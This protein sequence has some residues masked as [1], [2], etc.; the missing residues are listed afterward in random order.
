VRVLGND[1]VSRV[2]HVLRV[3]DNSLRA[4]NRAE[5]QLGEKENPSFYKE[6]WGYILMNYD[7]MVIDTRI[8]TV[9]AS[10][11]RVEDDY[12]LNLYCGSSRVG[13]YFD[14]TGLLFVHL[15]AISGIVI[16]GYLGTIHSVAPLEEAT[17]DGSVKFSMEP[18]MV[19]RTDFDGEF[20][21]EGFRIY[22]GCFKGECGFSFAEP[23]FRMDVPSGNELGRVLGGLKEEWERTRNLGQDVAKAESLL[24]KGVGSVLASLLQLNEEQI[25]EAYRRVLDHI[26]IAVDL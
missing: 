15:A 16:D 19:Y 12:N 17:L 3:L 23:F 25:Y 10:V 5:E 21:G 11:V 2:R 24:R 9:R 26:S 4:L 8:G 13:F 18:V 22:F 14:L 7:G 6:L 20:R 1:D